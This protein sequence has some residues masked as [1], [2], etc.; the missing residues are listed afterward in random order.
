MNWT[1]LTLAWREIN[2]NIMRSVLTCLGIIIGVAAVIVMVSVGEAATANVTQEIAGLGRNMLVVQPG[3]RQR[4]GQFIPAKPFEEADVEAIRDQVPGVADAAAI[5]L[6]N[7]Q[8]VFGNENFG[9]TIWGTET[10][11]YDVRDWDVVLGRRFTP[12][13]V[14]SGRPVCVLGETP[15]KALFGFRNPLGESIRMGSVTCE[16]I[17]VMEAKGANTF[18]QDQDDF[19]L[20]PI[21]LVQRRL[22][23]NR[24]VA[25]IMVS[26]QTEDVTND[27]KASIE[28]LMRER[29]KV[30]VGQPDDFTVQ[31][32]KE[33]SNILSQVT[34]ILTIFLS[35]V[36]AIS[37]LVGGIGIMNIMLVSVTE[38]TREIGIRLAIGALERDVLAQFLV[39][40]VMLSAFGGIIGVTLGLGLT[41]IGMQILGWPFIVNL[42]AV[43]GAVFFSAAIGVI[44]GFF[45]A[46]RAAQLDPIE[47][48]RYE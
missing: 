29:R 11:Y 46:R 32:L 28:G 39:E 3:Q 22:I 10:A 38:R 35:A 47:A 18:G 48:L 6:R 24:D 36:A 5:A 41:W 17:G 31:D 45:P 40:A 14:R 1:N 43:F 15:R 34:G 4:G 19:V 7:V 25:F 16:I 20:A 12:L 33:V 42:M 30:G 23:G 21:R 9:T 37:L 26:A 44:F 8:L 13:E 27:V 2:A